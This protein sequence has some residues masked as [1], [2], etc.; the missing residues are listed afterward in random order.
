ML[1]KNK[2]YLFGEIYEG[3]KLLKKLITKYHKVS[4][5]KIYIN[6]FLIDDPLKGCNELMKFYNNFKKYNDE[7]VL[8]KYRLISSFWKKEKLLE[9]LKQNKSCFGR[10]NYQCQKMQLGYLEKMN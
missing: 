3:R 10:K 9:Y 7:L 4:S 1:A 8:L 5:L 6:S 2:I